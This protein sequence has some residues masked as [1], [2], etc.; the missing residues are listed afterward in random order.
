MHTHTGTMLKPVAIS[1]QGHKNIS[2]KQS[3]TSLVL[4]NNNKIKYYNNS[5]PMQID[6]DCS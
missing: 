1:W 2:R 3:P 4:E 5:I 6:Q